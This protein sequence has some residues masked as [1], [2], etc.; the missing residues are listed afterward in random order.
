MSYI[1]L[2]L[3]L[4]SCAGP[5]AFNKKGDFY[6]RNN[7]YKLAAEKYRQNIKYYESINYPLYMLNLGVADYMSENY[8]EAEKAFLTA[9]KLSK[10]ENLNILEKNFG[11]LA[12]KTERTYKLRDYEEII[13]HFY[14]GLIYIK[15]NRINDAIVEFKKINLIDPEYPLIHYIMAKAYELQG[16]DEDSLIEYRLTKRYKPDFPYS[17]FDAALIY[18]K[19][20]YLDEYK[21]LMNKY[22]EIDK[23]GILK[24]FIN[25]LNDKIEV[26]FLID[27]DKFLKNVNKK[28]KE[29]CYLK[30][31]LNGKYEGRSFLIENIDFHK[32]KNRIKKLIKEKLKDTVRATVIKKVFNTEASSNTERR[33]WDKTPGI[34][35]IFKIYLGKGEYNLKAEIFLRDKKIKDIDLNKL[36]IRGERKIVFRGI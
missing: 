2:L 23:S 11:F 34:L 4:F 24:K 19:Q 27:M 20:G 12:P 16:K 9:L 32:T 26:I 17:Y 28:D 33:E 10:G 18:K 30:I 14:L 7:Q 8:V 3:F 5:I 21:M 25:K 6:Y 15:T 29:K 36:V 22:S 35:H 31:Y 13:V 1:F